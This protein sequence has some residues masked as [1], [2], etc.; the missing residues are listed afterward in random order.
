MFKAASFNSVVEAMAVAVVARAAVARVVEKTMT[1]WS[2]STVKKMN[3]SK[4]LVSS[5]S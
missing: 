2:P 1:F 4:L 3:Q 5:D